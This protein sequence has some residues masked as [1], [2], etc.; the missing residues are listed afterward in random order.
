MAPTSAKAACLY[1]NAARAIAEAQEAG[2][3][4]CVMRDANGNIA[5][6][7]TANIFIVFDG[8][9]HT[10][11]PNGTFLNGI[12]KQRVMKLLRGEGVEVIER[13]ITWDE[14]LAADEIF[15]TGNFAK[16]MPCTR[17]QDRQL[18]PGPLAAKARALYWDW[19]HGRL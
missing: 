2:F 6:F 13:A 5:E 14:V 7:A 4:N 16:V 17:I 11:A 8:A 15:A 19:A 9:A 1:P 18:S 10:P 3:D 12:T